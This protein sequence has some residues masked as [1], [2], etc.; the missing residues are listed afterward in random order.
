MNFPAAKAHNRDENP[1]S[2]PHTFWYSLLSPFL[3]SP[4]NAASYRRASA[5]RESY[6]QYLAALLLDFTIV[7]SRGRSW[8]HI[9]KPIIRATTLIITPCSSSSLLAIARR[10]QKEREKGKESSARG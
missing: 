8:A 1:E 2:L 5:K 4:L 6:L 9:F 10:S 7:D 3:V